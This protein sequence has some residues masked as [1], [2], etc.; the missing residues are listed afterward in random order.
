MTS[1]INSMNTNAYDRINEAH[2]HTHQATEKTD[3]NKQN[4]SV[5]NPQAADLETVQK[6]GGHG[7]GHG[8]G[9]AKIQEV[10]GTEKSFRSHFRHM[11]SPSDVI[12]HQ[13]LMR[14]LELQEQL[15]KAEQLKKKRLDQ[16]DK[17]DKRN[18]KDDH[19]DK[20]DNKK[21]KQN[22]FQQNKGKR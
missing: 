10:Q 19:K 6:H 11:K 21:K 9:H 18:V 17:L 8:G 1:P 3:S 14:D 16:L 5:Q 15:A 13:K 7:G 22:P 20:E 4:V 12:N 2:A